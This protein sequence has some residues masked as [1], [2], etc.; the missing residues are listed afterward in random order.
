METLCEVKALS[1]EGDHE[2]SNEWEILI[3]HAKYVQNRSGFLTED[4]KEPLSGFGPTT[5]ALPPPG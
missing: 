5:V 1:G 2:D 4:A 3:A